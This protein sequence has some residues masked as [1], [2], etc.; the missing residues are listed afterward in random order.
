MRTRVLSVSPDQSRQ[1]AILVA[2]IA[3]V[4]TVAGTAL[5][6]LLQWLVARSQRQW[7]REAEKT[8]RA[9][10]REDR[11]LE[12]REVRAQRLREEQH[13]AYRAF[14]IAVDEY[15][16][17]LRDVQAAGLPDNVHV[18]SSVD[19]ESKWPIGA[20]VLRASTA[21]AGAVT[22]VLLHC[23]ARVGESAAVLVTVLNRAL[24]KASR[25]E[26]FDEEVNKRRSEVVLEMREELGSG[27]LGGSKPGS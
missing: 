7:S 18:A 19:L 13:D 20:R 1:L 3:G 4:A 5:G 27:P 24:D 16:A 23:D 15:I 6:A 17:A 22:D 9:E 8:R 11:G 21:L 2:C 26:A 25:K 12:M 10:E 14:L